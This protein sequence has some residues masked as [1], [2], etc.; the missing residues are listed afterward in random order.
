MSDEP[1][2]QAAQTQ[3]PTE[4]R[5]SEVMGDSVPDP[6]G[7]G[8]TGITSSGAPAQWIAQ[9]VNAIRPL[10]ENLHQS[11]LALIASNRAL[12]EQLDAKTRREAQRWVSTARA[13]EMLNVGEETVI[14][15]ITKNCLIGRKT[16][17]KRSRWEVDVT[18]I[19]RLANAS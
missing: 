19:E 16:G 9:L 15:R 11:N 7:P 12:C 14:R 17:G 2:A 13:A 10:I 4:A 5:D 1:P 6:N 18:S 8:E 3:C